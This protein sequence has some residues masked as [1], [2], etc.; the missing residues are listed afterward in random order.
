V[1]HV[2]VG[3][4]TGTRLG[5][6]CNTFGR[7]IAEDGARPILEAA[8]DC[9]IRWL[10]TADIYPPPAPGS[11][12]TI[13]GNVM[14]R[15]REEV[16]L[17]TKFGWNFG[18][19]HGKGGDAKFIQ[20]SLEASLRRLRTDWIDLYQF[21][22]PDPGTPMGRTIAAMATHVETGKVRQIGCSNFSAAQLTEAL[23]V[24][25]EL[26]LPAFVSVQNEYSVLRPHR[27]AEVVPVC[28]DRGLAMI[29]YFAVAGGL[30][31]GKYRLGSMPGNTRLTKSSW[32]GKFLPDR[33]ID[34]VEAL[35]GYA[36]RHGH[37][38]IDLALGWV[39]SQPG[40]GVVLTGATS[41]EQIRANAAAVGSWTLTPEQVVEAERIAFEALPEDLRH[42]P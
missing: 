41:P 21:H 7:G 13:L 16:V 18:G 27:A 15:H 9:G 24:A 3:T 11:S 10:D 8:I 29:P 33:Q 6:G 28:V 12:E 31:T 32:G 19:E 30:L 17:A 36:A 25:E 26:G 38:I 2:R 20:S 40:V 39:A 4:L 5:L 23:K 14:G 22:R 1:E 35:A 34:A 42:R 37:S